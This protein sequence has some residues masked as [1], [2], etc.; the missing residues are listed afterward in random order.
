MLRGLKH[1]DQTL[2]SIAE[3]CLIGSSVQIFKAISNKIISRWRNPRQN[4]SSGYFNTFKQRH[5]QFQTNTV[6]EISLWNPRSN[7]NSWKYLI[8]CSLKLSHK[9][10]SS[11][12]DNLF[13]DQTKLSIKMTRSRFKKE[14]C[15]QSHRK[16]T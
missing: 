11:L 4:P 6:P 3:R 5:R 10:L 8:C 13:I 2:S 15:D 9:L 16:T 7:S 12:N 1:R 14:E